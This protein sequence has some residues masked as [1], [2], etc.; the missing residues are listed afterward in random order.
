MIRKLL[1]GT[2]PSILRS[3][4]PGILN[5]SSATR[6]NL[7]MYPRDS[8]S[9]V[10]PSATDNVMMSHTHGEGAWTPP[11]QQIERERGRRGGRWENQCSEIIFE[12]WPP[13]SFSA[14]VEKCW[15]TSRQH[16]KQIEDDSRLFFHQNIKKNSKISKIG[17]N[18]TLQNRR[19]W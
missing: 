15:K 16:Q 3:C 8:R 12:L 2:V 19:L 7:E 4:I 11:T 14:V 9:I 10:N 5:S 18:H 17:T 6:L 1:P 13:V